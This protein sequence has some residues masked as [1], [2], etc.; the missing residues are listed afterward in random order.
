MEKPAH[1]YELFSE[2]VRICP[3]EEPDPA[4]LYRSLR[5]MEEDRLV[6]SE[7]DTG[8]PGPARRVYRITEL[9]QEEEALYY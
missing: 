7:W 3:E 4:G 8:D 9:G 2:L 5:E 6:T 1:G